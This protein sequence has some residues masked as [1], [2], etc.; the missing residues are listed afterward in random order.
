SVHPSGARSSTDDRAFRQ[1]IEKRMRIHATDRRLHLIEL[2]DLSSEPPHDLVTSNRVFL[3]T[4]VTW[5]AQ[6]LCRPHHQLDRNGPVCP[7]VATSM[8]RELFF[9]SVYRGDL[10]AADVSGIASQYADWFVDLEPRAGDAAQYKTILLLFPDVP[11][12]RA[13]DLID[14]TQA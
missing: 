6:Y 9:L 10:T 14:H 4:I 1:R 5:A 11:A 2:S 12:S 13:Q 8:D 3:D 7:F